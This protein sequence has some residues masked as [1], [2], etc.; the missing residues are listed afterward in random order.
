MATAHTRITE[1]IRVPLSRKYLLGL[2]PSGFHRLS[3]TDWG[4]ARSPHV[5]VCVHGLTRNARDFDFLAQALESSCRVICPDVVGRGQSGWLARKDDYA[6]PQYLTDMTALIARITEHLQPDARIDWVGTSMGGLIGMLLA[7]QPAHPIR[8]MVLNDVGPFIPKTALARIALYVG[9]APRFA[10][11][12]EAERYVRIVSAPF[13]PLTDVQ[14]RHLTEHNMHRD[15]DGSCVMRYDPGIANAFATQSLQDV[16]L[17]SHWDRIDCPVLTLRG[18]N[19]DVLSHAT[20]EEMT[21]RGPRARLVEFAGIG[22]A[23]TLMAADQIEAVRDFL[24][25]PDR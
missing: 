19:S 11:L 20:A 23:P 18:K 17:W 1:I 10:S 2:S 22:H 16:D 3:Y 15:A 24:L 7:A 9:K 14:W 8:R 4:E 25:T 6:Y 12:D 13:G 5:V 21:R